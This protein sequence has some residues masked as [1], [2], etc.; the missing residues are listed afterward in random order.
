MKFGILNIGC[1]KNAYKTYKTS[2]FLY[3]SRFAVDWSNLRNI[4]KTYE[5]SGSLC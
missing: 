5:T 3:W 2:A 4:Y 1:L